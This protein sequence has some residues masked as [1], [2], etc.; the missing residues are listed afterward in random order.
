MRGFL[1]LFLVQSAASHALCPRVSSAATNGLLALCDSTK[2]GKITACELSWCITRGAWGGAACGSH[3]DC[4]TAEIDECPSTE[5]GHVPTAAELIYTYDTN[6]DHMLDA[7]EL[8]A[9]APR[10]LLAVLTTREGSAM[11]EKL[12]P[13][14]YVFEGTVAVDEHA[15]HNHRRSSGSR[16]QGH[17]HG[18]G[19][20]EEHEHEH[21][22]EPE[23]GFDFMDIDE[24][25]LTELWTKFSITPFGTI[26]EAHDH[27]HEH[28][29]EHEHEHEE[30]DHTGHNHRRSA[31]PTQVSSARL[32][33]HPAVRAAKGSNALKLA[34][35]T[36]FHGAVRS[37][38]TSALS[39]VNSIRSY[40]RP[41]LVA[42]L[43]TSISAV[44]G[45]DMDLG[46]NPKLGAYSAA[47]ANASSS[48]LRGARA[49]E[50]EEEHDHD[51]G[52]P[53]LS[54]PDAFKAADLDNSGHLTV[55]ELPVALGNLL[56]CI[57]GDEAHDHGSTCSRPSTAE[58]WF[59]TFIATVIISLISVVGILVVPMGS[60]LRYAL[61]LLVSFAVGALLA[62]VLL[63]IIPHTLPINVKE[64]SEGDHSGHDHSAPI[65]KGSMY[66][67]LVLMCGSIW[68]FFLFER[69]VRLLAGGSHGHTSFHEDSANGG[70]HHG[71]HDPSNTVTTDLVSGGGGALDLNDKKRIKCDA[72]FGSR[73]WLYHV[74]LGPVYFARSDGKTPSFWKG[75]LAPVAY[76]NLFSDGIH[77]FV[78]GI[79]LGV[80][81][82]KDFD[83]GVTTAIAI[84]FHE[85]A[86]E[87]G[88]FAILLSA[89]MAK[90]QAVLANLA[91]ACLAIIGGF[92]GCAIGSGGDDVATWVLC[93]GA[94]GFLYIALSAM[95]PEL[96]D[97]PAGSGD[98][99]SFKNFFSWRFWR[100]VVLDTLGFSIGIVVLWIIAVTE[101]HGDC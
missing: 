14:R 86:Q 101:N 17:D 24:T 6:H 32:S 39:V 82:T 53:C 30:E 45:E 42:A 87:F 78:D 36:G 28:E 83:L 37:A 63:H 91:C 70:D 75:E 7:A 21:E 71:K 13:L 3:T 77:N 98:K 43:Y 79:T 26:E 9:A 81:F 59:A 52:P 94:G 5:L 50:D 11:T 12:E 33:L 93:F 20:E 25:T 34:K 41:A 68:V 2:D 90:W 72:K 80:A 62:D 97:P 19:E 74:L 99:A 18:H 55:L 46:K 60:F 40:V 64:D 1:I 58:A 16:R 84:L 47:Y 15:G 35:S 76:V 56:R 66:G 95:L 22:H 48:R 73:A 29:E 100:D 61:R 49:A 89:G 92:V 69:L 44:R 4:D 54:G 96:V 23:H 10:V 31:K 85:I 51:H 57:M 27:E 67:R 65:S 38:T 88:D 8:A